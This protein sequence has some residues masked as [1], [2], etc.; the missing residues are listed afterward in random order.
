MKIGYAMI[1]IFLLAFSPAA[2]SAEK[3]TVIDGWIHL[4]VP[5][6]LTAYAVSSI[7]NTT[8]D[9][10]VHEERVDVRFFENNGTI[11]LPFPNGNGKLTGFS[12]SAYNTTFNV[13]SLN[14]TL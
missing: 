1:L 2:V 5:T 8:I 3:A 10:N 11:E 13:T 14:Y 9:Y 6:G 12:V 7:W 4:D